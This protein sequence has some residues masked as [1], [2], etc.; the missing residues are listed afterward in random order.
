MEMRLRN[1]IDNPKPGTVY[2]TVNDVTLKTCGMKE[3]SPP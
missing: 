1:A 3:A 2:R